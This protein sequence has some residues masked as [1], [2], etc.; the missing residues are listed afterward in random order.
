MTLFPRSSFVT[1]NTSANMGL[2]N[3]RFAPSRESEPHQL[4]GMDKHL[5]KTLIEPAQDRSEGKNIFS[6]DTQTMSE[7]C[8]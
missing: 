4:A 2:C 5:P 7:I 6:N 3:R 1:P 8:A